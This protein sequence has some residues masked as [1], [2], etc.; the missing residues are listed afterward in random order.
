MYKK[1]E[2]RLKVLKLENK[3]SFIAK[4]S[5][6]DK[7]QLV[8]MNHEHLLYYLLY[9]K[10]GENYQWNERLVWDKD[11][12]INYLNDRNTYFFIGI[13]NNEII[14]FA[15]INLEEHQFAEIKYFGLLPNFIGQGLGGL[16]LSSLIEKCFELHASG[17]FLKTCK[18]D[19]PNAMA[20][21]KARGF[22]V[23]GNDSFL[24]EY[25]HPQQREAIIHE[26]MIGA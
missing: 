26:F 1:K 22:K 13:H 16:F 19:H 6:F 5:R 14:G 17:V 23:V 20:N 4:K 18:N 7:I 10:V 24:E 25:F 15:D 2:I 9:S 12:L 21:Y 8:Q 3:E 11:K